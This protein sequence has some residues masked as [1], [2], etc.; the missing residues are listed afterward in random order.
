MT[1]TSKECLFAVAVLLFAFGAWAGDSE[2]DAVDG[3]L[4][5]NCGWEGNCWGGWHPSTNIDVGRDGSAH[6]G[7]YYG[8]IAP[9]SG[10]EGAAQE[11]LNTI[12]GQSYTLSFWV[13]N[14][15]PIERLQVTWYSLE[16]P[17]EVV[18]DLAD[19]PPEDWTQIVI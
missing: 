8:I 5:A 2:C 9:H 17:G 13:R 16:S 14:A 4:V 10:L 6:S 15:D 19:L 3:N 1:S 11:D 7:D 18:L 12:V